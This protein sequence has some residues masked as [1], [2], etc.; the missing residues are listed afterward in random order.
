MSK[1]NLN[2]QITKVSF[3]EKQVSNDLQLKQIELSKQ[4]VSPALDTRDNFLNSSRENNFITKE[5]LKLDKESVVQLQELKPDEIQLKKVLKKMIINYSVKYNDRSFECLHS[6]ENDF[7]EKSKIMGL[8][9]ID[10]FFRLMACNDP[11]LKYRFEN[12]EIIGRKAVYSGCV[13]DSG[14][15]DNSTCTEEVLEDGDT[16]ILNHTYYHDHDYDYVF[17]KNDPDK[18]DNNELINLSNNNF[19]EIEQKQPDKPNN[20]G[21]SWILEQYL[22]QQVVDFSK[23]AANQLIDRS[24]SKAILNMLV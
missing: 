6:Y 11:T 19:S 16:I 13:N 1:I 14:R 4:I 12:L 18:N 7:S 10:T 5:S 9:N 3:P 17:P 2:N 8:D 15:R 20:S 24:I 23:F 21:G 22:K